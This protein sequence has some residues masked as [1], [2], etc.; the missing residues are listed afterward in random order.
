MFETP[1]QFRDR[2]RET[3]KGSFA[4]EAEAKGIQTLS[5][6][7]PVNAQGQQTSGKPISGEAPKQAPPI[8]KEFKGALQMA[9]EQI[10]TAFKSRA[11]LDSGTKLKNSGRVAEQ[12][13]KDMYAAVNNPNTD[14]K[15][16]SDVFSKNFDKVVDQVVKETEGLVKQNQ[17]KQQNT[18]QQ[19]QQKDLKNQ[20]LNAEDGHGDLQVADEAYGDGVKNFVSPTETVG[21]GDMNSPVTERQDPISVDSFQKVLQFATPQN[22]ADAIKKM[23]PEDFAQ[24][25]SGLQKTALDMLAKSVNAGGGSGGPVDNSKPQGKNNNPT[26]SGGN[27]DKEGNLKLGDL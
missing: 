15:V 20:V 14:M 6:V 2:I 27:T 7:D 11:S 21:T 24:F 3:L 4:K 16:M 12:S 18:D 22:I 23:P 5:E 25:T 1:D 13:I 17:N 9:F 8:E 26:G 10:S 19:T